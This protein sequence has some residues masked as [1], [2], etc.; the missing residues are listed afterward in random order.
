LAQPRLDGARGSFQSLLDKNKSDA[1][2]ETGLAL[3][4]LVQAQVSFQLGDSQQALQELDAAD[5]R[6]QNAAQLAPNFLIRE[7]TSAAQK[8]RGDLEGGL[9]RVPPDA[10]GQVPIVD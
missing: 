8:L 10:T 4:A 7:A 6:L 5:L 2:A 9:K 1:S 3:V